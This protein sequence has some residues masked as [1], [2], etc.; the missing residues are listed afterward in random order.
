L[1]PAG[2]PWRPLFFDVVPDSGVSGIAAAQDGTIPAGLMPHAPMIRNVV[3]RGDGVAARCCAHLLNRGGF[4]VGLQRIDR[5]RVPAIMLGD[6]AAALI[7]DVFDLPGLF[8]ERPRI[9]GRV[10]A[11]GEGERA[12]LLPHS[13]VVV[14]E[15]ELLDGL[16]L[17]GEHVYSAEF[18][19]DFT[20]YASGTLPLAVTQRS[21]GSRRASAARVSLAGAEPSASEPSASY[22]ESL[23]SG[24]LFLVPRGSASAWLLAI[25]DQLERQLARSR[26]IAPL[27]DSMAL[28]SGEFPASPRIA[29]PLCG[30]GWL[31]CGSAGLAF[32]PICGDGTAQAVR[33]AI[34]ACAVIRAISNGGDADSLLAHYETRLLAGMQRHLGL[35]SEFYR[36]GGEGLWWKAELQSLWEGFQWCSAKR[37]AAPEARYTLRDFELERRTPT[38]I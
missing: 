1:S 11:W 5:P 23:E 4:R 28:V 30:P 6:T 3:I 8:E 14:S 33:E 38:M 29:V 26:I 21:F 31:A 13:A 19:P 37:A 16:G 36:S 27:I 22:I 32:D 15:E 12:R 24:W 20:I 35:C 18:A 2:A 10:V 7:R 9:T 17:S 34:L 25:G